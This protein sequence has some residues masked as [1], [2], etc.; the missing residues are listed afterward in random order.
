VYAVAGHAATGRFATGGG[1]DRAFLWS[2][3]LAPA[4]LWQ[5]FTVPQLQ[6]D[7]LLGATELAGHGDSVAAVGFRFVLVEHARPVS[8]L[9]PTS[10]PM[11][12][13]L[14]RLAWTA[15]CWSGAPLRS[16][17][18]LQRLFR[19]FCRPHPGARRMLRCIR[20]LRAPGSRWT[21]CSGTHEAQCCWQAL[22]TSQPGSGTPQT[23]RVC[24][25]A[26]T[27]QI[28]RYSY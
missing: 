5:W 10:V 20:R 8:L 24:R 16:E 3:R 2:V 19:L 21:G 26:Q 11:V 27:R 14:Q 13:F 6:Q 1:D 28:L 25:H 22:R 7:G 15:K 9:T 18:L 12:P 17:S 23:G 4:S